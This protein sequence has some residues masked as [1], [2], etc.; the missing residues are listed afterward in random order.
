MK[1]KVKQKRAGNPP[2][3]M[4]EK[5]DED[6][7]DRKLGIGE[8]VNKLRVRERSSLLDNVQT[9]MEKGIE[10][11]NYGTKQKDFKD[12][13]IEVNE[14]VAYDGGQDDHSHEAPS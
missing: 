1:K 4:E 2:S 13:N 8:P 12:W 5:G 10:Q 7:I 9:T 3:V 14:L 11:G 6:P